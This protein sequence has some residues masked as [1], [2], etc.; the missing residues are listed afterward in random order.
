M[1]STD[2]IQFGRLA[3]GHNFVTHEELTKALQEQERQRLEEGVAPR[4][5]EVLVSMGLMTSQQIEQL[6]DEQAGRHGGKVLGGYEL[7]ERI[8]SGGMGAV[9]KARQTSL[10]R[11]VA[12]KVLPQRLAR[13]KDFIA[14]F[15]REARAVAKFSHPNIVSGFEVGE[16]EGYHFL[17]MEFVDG[18][19]AAEQLAKTP[20]GVPVG[21]VLK[22]ALQIG[23][24]LQHA[25]ENNIIHRDVKPENILI[26]SDGTAKLCDLGLARSAGNEDAALTQ[27]G[28]AVGTPHYISPEQARGRGDLDPRA[29]IYSFGATLFHLVTGRP[30]FTGDNPLQIMT[31]HLEDPPPLAA[32]VSPAV[33]AEL[34]A[35]IDK[36]LA[37]RRDDRYP[38]MADVIE[39]LQLVSEGHSPVHAQI[40]RRSQRRAGPQASPPRRRSP[41]RKINT[42]V[43]RA[44]VARKRH[45][46]QLAALMLVGALLLFG[47]GFLFWRSLKSRPSS[48]ASNGHK[49]TDPH[50]IPTHRATPEELKQARFKRL[51]ASAVAFAKE[52][53]GSYRKQ[54]TRFEYV[55]RK[56]GPKSPWGRKSSRRA[57]EIEAELEK[58]IAAA[59]RPLRARARKLLDSRQYGS[60]VALFRSLPTD[61]AYSREASSLKLAAAE[62]KKCEAAG[63]DDWNKL[64]A[65]SRARLELHDFPGARK[66]A[67]AASGFDLPE[68]STRLGTQLTAIDDAEASFRKA[69][70]AQARKSFGLFVPAFRKA[71]A[72]RKYSAARKVYDQTLAAML[73][74][75]SKL[76]PEVDRGM[77]LELTDMKSCEA[78]F[79]AVL[80]R[81]R[82]AKRGDR[83]ELPSPLTGRP[84]SG[85]FESFIETTQTVV[86]S[87][88]R[89]KRHLPFKVS[90]FSCEKMLALAGL[91]WGVSKPENVRKVIVFTCRDAKATETDI[92]IV[93]TLARTRKFDAGRYIGKLDDLKASHLDGEAQRVFEGLRS[94]VKAGRWQQALSAA[95]S[96]ISGAYD[97]A[98]TLKDN[99]AEIQNLRKTAIAKL[100]TRKTTRLT[101]QYGAPLWGLGSGYYRGVEDTL[102][103]D[104]TRRDTA[105]GGARFIKLG[106]KSARLL[107]RFDLSLL[108]RGLQL[109]SAKLQLFCARKGAGA[110][111]KLRVYCLNRAW[112]AGKLYRAA[113]A[114]ADGATWTLSSSGPAG[115]LSWKT[116]GG[117][118]DTASDYGK[119]RGILDEVA[120]PGA[121]QWVSLDVT[122]AL[123]G[124]LSGSKRNYGFLVMSSGAASARMLLASSDA[125]DV[126]AGRRPR[127][128]IEAVNFSPAYAP[129][130][131]VKRTAATYQFAAAAD[132]TV[133]AEQ[134]IVRRGVTGR[135]V[136]RGLTYAKGAL[137]FLHDK[138]PYSI[139]TR[140][141]RWTG[142]LEVGTQVRMPSGG[143]VGLAFEKPLADSKARCLK[144]NCYP[145]QKSIAGVFGTGLPGYSKLPGTMGSN[146]S[147]DTPTVLRHRHFAADGVY[148]LRFIK[149]GHRLRLLVNGRCLAELGMT[150]REALLLAR[151]PIRI[152]VRPPK[153]QEGISPII[154]LKEIYVGPVRADSKTTG[155]SD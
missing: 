126:R 133:F 110:A 86:L 60:A 9:Y 45:P 54:I 108:P 63:L 112:K 18:Q 118:L 144:F 12:L 136:R 114:A 128:V 27:A 11:I 147:S 24:A 34:S 39:D 103:R 107:V 8:G 111:G 77:K 30:V 96:L 33:S 117:D 101:L 40:D 51:Y 141:N 104:G 1:P 123:K 78:V 154:D 79:E 125:L 23:E 62:I 153:A 84:M 89:G 43:M 76:P 105:M 16:A 35:V 36:M 74:A 143:T 152:V 99:R 49:K 31:K 130:A 69:G 52:H 56:T 132:L 119:G 32:E 97:A 67:N 151:Q 115:R 38:V 83:F 65:T 82:K 129:P 26:S 80:E 88:N 19:S 25:H 148:D 85:S 92:R 6:V 21:K 53:Q 64:L 90:S 15:Y 91:G 7:L 71:I 61:F 13:D 113:G 139:E 29:D 75:S 102:I 94:H 37:K 81:F 2:D 58:A 73:K 55:V 106:S 4:L 66:A 137:R 93:R 149:E 127:L 109:K 46:Q 140:N 3:L 10:N 14:R 116:P 146:S 142:D 155:A 150:P 145:S 131:A 44:A 28:M 5:G 50:K 138:L 57:A 87:R 134:F 121:K 17:A 47:G 22:M 122:T 98:P 48:S 68:V 41:T 42:S 124:M 20:A 135:R 100:G 72:E 70:A 95:D 120:A 59:F